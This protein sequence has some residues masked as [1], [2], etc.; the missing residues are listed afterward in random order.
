[1]DVTGSRQPDP[2]LSGFRMEPYRI[3]AGIILLAC[4]V[5]VFLI[6]RSFLWS[7]FLSVVLYTSF[8]GVNRRILL[9]LKGRRTAAAALSTLL[10]VGLVLA[11]LG[12]MAQQLIMELLSLYETTRQAIVGERLFQ[13]IQNFPALIQ[14]LTRDPTFWVD[15]Y[16]LLEFIYSEYINYMDIDQL[17]NWLGGA[18]SLL[19][20]GISFA[21]LAAGNLFF[22]VLLLFFLFKDAE[23][24]QLYIR[25]ML[26]LPEHYVQDFAQRSKMILVAVLKG[27]LLISLLQG[28]ALGIAFV[29]AGIPNP[30]AYAFIATILSLIPVVGTALV[31]LPA[32]LYLGFFQNAYWTAFLLGSF[33]LIAYLLLENVLKPRILD[34]KLGIHPL[35]LFL[36]ILGGLK[37]F[38]MGGLIIGP[39]MVTLFVSLWSTLINERKKSLLHPATQPDHQRHARTEQTPAQH[40]D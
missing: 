8:G 32:C 35:F 14:L 12:F 39:L 31:W 38:G 15:Y 11:P 4:A 9:R 10:S 18:T 21:L 23:Y 30:L 34:R 36:A 37:E 40:L 22:T 17:S 2:P 33:C 1:M 28:A 5:F 6:Y 7:A 26:P 20:G 3:V 29:I 19:M 16:R 24:F 13:T 27:N 25:R